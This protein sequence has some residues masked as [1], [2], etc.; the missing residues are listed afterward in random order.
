MSGRQPGIT[1][2]IATAV[3]DPTDASLQRVPG[4]VN[5]LATLDG[6]YLDISQL[7]PAVVAGLA[8]QAPWNAATNT[9]TLPPVSTPAVGAF[10]PVSVAGS[11][12]LPGAPGPWTTAQA[13]VFNGVTWSTVAFIQL[14][15]GQ[16]VPTGS[17]GQVLYL[18]ASKLLQTGSL[19]TVGAL[20]LA[21]VAGGQTATGGTA[22]SENLTL[23]STAHATKGAVVIAIGDNLDASGAVSMK[24]PV[25][26]G[27]APTA[28]GAVALNSSNNTLVFGDGADTLTVLD[29]AMIGV[30]VQAYSA[31]LAALV[32]NGTPSA[33][34][35]ARIKDADQA[36]NRTALGLGSAAYTA[37]TAYDVAGA[38]AAA[39]AASQ[40]A[41][42]VLTAYV[43]AGNPT[44]TPGNN[45]VPISDGSGKLTAWIANVIGDSGSGGTAGLVPAPASGDAAAGKFLKADGTFAVPGSTVPTI[46]AAWTAS[47]FSPGATWEITTTAQVPGRPVARVKEINTFTVSNTIFATSPEFGW[48]LLNTANIRNATDNSTVAGSAYAQ[49]TTTN[50]DWTGVGQIAGFRYQKFTGYDG[51][52][53]QLVGV[54]TSNGSANFEQT[55]IIICDDAGKGT[56]YLKIAIGFDTARRI[57]IYGAASSVVTTVTSGQL[58]AG[59]GLRVTLNG[60][61]TAGV[62]V[63]VEYNLTP[64]TPPPATSW[65]RALSVAMDLQG[66]TVD[67]GWF[68]QSGNTTGNHIAT[69]AYWAW[70]A[71]YVTSACTVPTFQAT[72]QQTGTAQNIGEVDL[73]SQSAVIN[74]TLLRL[75]LTDAINRLITSGNPD[76]A[77]ITVAVNQSTTPGTGIGGLSYA[78]ASSFT[79]TGTGK[80][81]TL[82]LQSAGNLPGSLMF[83]IP[84]PITSS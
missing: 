43:S 76:A 57:Q 26:A 35:L 32:A 61:S 41:S 12:A 56:T 53:V 79:P 10:W 48:L 54:F 27:A 44:A 14:A 22:A 78:S 28:L 84:V 3:Q 50:S 46:G 80:Y 34:G 82:A 42:S 16:I 4:A 15:I 55:G 39:Q 37:S 1:T 19:A 18:D 38:A 11:T 33:W 67:L 17:A 9:P 31:I 13:A 25:S 59:I 7:P 6:M 62:I 64:G 73:G 36:A 20:T 49:V 66:K 74:T 81:A 60:T 24:V 58:S 83:P 51:R 77:T 71:Q 23:R 29:S 47:N 63:T 30:T 52:F 2:R 8:Y 68:I 72:Q 69:C 70:T 45:K 40:P 5:G 21:G 75:Y 65:V